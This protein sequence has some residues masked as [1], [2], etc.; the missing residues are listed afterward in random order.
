M[1]YKASLGFRYDHSNKRT[2]KLLPY[3]LS[4]TRPTAG[5]FGISTYETTERKE[6]LGSG[7]AKKYMFLHALKTIN[8]IR[9]TA[10]WF[11]NKVL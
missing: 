3:T 5:A 10:Q 9:S 1:L 7:D 8:K 2:S 11:Q 6:K 4:R